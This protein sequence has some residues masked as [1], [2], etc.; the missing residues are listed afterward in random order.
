MSSVQANREHKVGHQAVT[1]KKE[2][3]KYLQIRTKLLDERVTSYLNSLERRFN[4]EKHT[5]HDLSV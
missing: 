3:Q 5:V 4:E 1:L 2:T